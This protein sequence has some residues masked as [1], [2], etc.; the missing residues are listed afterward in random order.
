MLDPPA[1]RDTLLSALEATVFAGWASSAPLL[2]EI[3][4]TAGELPATGDPPDSAPSLL[5]QGYTARADGRVR[6]GRAGVAARDP[7]LPR[8]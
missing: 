3:A 2:Q 8:R 1:A 5:L 7:G 6:G 4:Q